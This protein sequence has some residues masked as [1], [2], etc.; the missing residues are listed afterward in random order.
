MFRFVLIML[1]LLVAGCGHHGNMA[2]RGDGELV[3]VVV[4]LGLTADMD[5][6]EM[7]QRQLVADFMRRDLISRLRHL[8]YEVDSFEQRGDFVSGR[9]QS[10]LAVKI[11]HYRPGSKSAQMTVGFGAGS[12]G[13]YISYSIIDET[14]STLVSATDGVGS[15]RDWSSSCR[16]LNE[17][18]VKVLG[19]VL[20]MPN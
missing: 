2:S 14:G 12:T 10:L 3:G 9:G 16:V 4:D 18:L 8:G 13:L 7:S 1:V 17:R 6:A 5:N 19:S 15:S 20:A 11:E